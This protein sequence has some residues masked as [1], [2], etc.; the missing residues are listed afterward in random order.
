MGNKASK[1]FENLAPAISELA[2][3]IRNSKRSHG[4]QH[5]A[6][7]RRAKANSIMSWANLVFVGL[8]IS[9]AFSD[10]FNSLVAVIGGVAFLAAYYVADR[11]MKGGDHQ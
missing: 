9:Q 4:L 8:V 11:I 5:N 3:A 1:R 10:K 2:S 7:N 6:E